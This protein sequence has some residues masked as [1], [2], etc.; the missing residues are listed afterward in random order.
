MLRIGTFVPDQIKGLRCRNAIRRQEPCQTLNHR[1]KNLQF[2]FVDVFIKP[3]FQSRPR[4][5]PVLSQF[6]ISS[7][8]KSQLFPFW[9]PLWR[10]LP[11]K[12][13]H[14]CNQDVDFKPL[15]W[16]CF[17]REIIDLQ[18]MSVSIS[19][20]VGGGNL[21]IKPARHKS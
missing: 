14:R 7:S 9:L 17:E 18:Q 5:L 3:L 6:K 12:V 10:Q 20:S 2:R 11:H 21:T 1:K 4:E 15:E 16:Q 19:Q 13:D 8:I